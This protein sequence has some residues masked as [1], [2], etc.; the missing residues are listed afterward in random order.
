M[1]GVNLGALGAVLCVVLLTLRPDL[2]FNTL[3][4]FREIMHE[5]DKRAEQVSSF[6]SGTHSFEHGPGF[7][8]L[9]LPEIQLGETGTR[10]FKGPELEELAGD[11]GQDQ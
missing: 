5:K 7:Y 4:S 2:G 8:N 6:G 1:N 3:H 11:V 10:R 9:P